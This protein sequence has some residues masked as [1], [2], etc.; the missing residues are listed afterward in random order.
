MEQKLLIL[1]NKIQIKFN[2]F[3]LLKTALT[4]R[5]YINEHRK[6]NLL[7]NERLEFLGDAVLELAVTEYLFNSFQDKPE[8]ELT[9]LRAALV[10]GETLAKIGKE[11]EIDK[12]LL[13]SRGETKAKGRSRNYLTANAVEAILGA[14]YL[15]QGFDKAYQFIET[16]I[17]KELPQIIDQNLYRDA[18]STFQEKAQEIENI[19]PTYKLHKESGPDHNRHF[20]IGVYLNK[21]LIAE[22][23]GKSKQEAQQMAAAKALD[24]KNWN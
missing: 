16:F 18:K 6:E 5:S 17:L 8:G 3:N 15:D 11:L 2:D 24:I 7:H 21:K 23:E 4:H 19:T 9:N 14:I 13:L 12:N 10:K 20:L 1:S 22:G